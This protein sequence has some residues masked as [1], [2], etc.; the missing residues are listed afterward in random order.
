MGIP[1]DWIPKWVPAIVSGAALGF[2]LG[3]NVL[4]V[5]FKEGHPIQN[6]VRGDKRGREKDSSKPLETTEASGLVYSLL[7]CKAHRRIGLI[8]I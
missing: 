1:V 8:G 5:Q 3:T 2:F 4:R 7:I 6:M